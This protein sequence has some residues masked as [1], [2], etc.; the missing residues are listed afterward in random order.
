MSRLVLRAMGIFGGVQSLQILCGV[1][2]M[3]LVSLWIGPAGV[4]LF[5]I[6]NQAIDLVATATQLSLRTS[7]VRD[8]AAART[9][10]AAVLAAIVV[11][12]RR[13]GWFLGLVG[14]L[15][16]LIASPWLSLSTFGNYGHSFQY[17]LLSVSVFFSALIGSESAIL[18]GLERYR[19]LALGSL[20]GALGGLVV[21]IPMY[22]FMGIESIIPSLIAY[23]LATGG[24]LLF[25]RAK[26]QKPDHRVTIRETFDTGRSFL[27]LGGLLTVS[28]F[29]EQLCSYTFTAYLNIEGTDVTVGY[30]QS[31]YTL[32]N[33]YVGLIFAALGMEYYPRL[34]RVSGSIMRTRVYVSHEM[35]IIMIM[36]VPVTTVFITAVQLIIKILYSAEF[37]EIMPFVVTAM[38]GMVFRGF[39]WCY[40]FL[41]LAWNRGRIFVIIECISSVTGLV[42]N[43]IAFKLYGISGLGIS[44][45]VWYLIYSIMLV[46][47]C[48]RLGVTV[49]RRSIRLMLY[50]LVA[51]SLQVAF[52][53]LFPVWVQIAYASAATIFS[54]ILLL[55]LSG[56]RF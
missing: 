21:S 3:K 6:F 33:K 36:I 52:H 20:W 11:T 1:I 13:C 37:L 12:V 25:Y 40:S 56:S 10:S 45:T 41:L 22:Y 5:S 32:I 51:T 15:V 4:G 16:M 39:S 18:Q 9:K 2:R 50:A 30:Y 47:V 43:I 48:H 44:F 17:V 19:P 49:S 14:A 27:L 23:S 35:S 31:G 53:F 26:D 29:V 34:S 54:L 7:A 42:L 24:A 38:A 28:A 46:I 8:I 55:K